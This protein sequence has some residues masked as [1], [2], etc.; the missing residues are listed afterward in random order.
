MLFELIN[1]SVTFQSYINNALRE[2][3]NIFALV[4]QDD[5]LIYFTVK[6]EHT[7]HVRQMLV[8]LR[9]YRL[10]LNLKKCDFSVYETCFLDFVLSVVDI[11][12]KSDRVATIK[13]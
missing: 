4:Y 5:I 11:A 8:K 10:F 12:M 6:V 1:D 9:K 3:L 7:T 13:D 2:Y